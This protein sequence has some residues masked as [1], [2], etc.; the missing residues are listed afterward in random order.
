MLKGFLSSFD[1]HCIPSGMTSLM[2]WFVKPRFSKGM[3]CWNGL[4]QGERK[5][6]T[7]PEVGYHTRENTLTVRF[8][9]T[10]RGRY[11]EVMFLWKGV[12]RL[13]NACCV[14]VGWQ[15]GLPGQ[16]ITEHFTPKPGHSQEGGLKRSVLAKVQEPG[17]R[18]E[19]GRYFG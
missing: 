7:V 18:W 3:L 6:V 17:A 5:A 1:P 2:E 16:Y 8:T 12:S 15:S 13:E 9:S 11:K 14:A 19:A 4:L 10:P